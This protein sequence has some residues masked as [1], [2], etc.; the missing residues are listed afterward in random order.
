[1]V[2]PPRAVKLGNQFDVLVSIGGE[3]F[4]TPTALENNAL[5][6]EPM[7]ARPGS[8][9]GINCVP[10]RGFIVNETDANR[11]SSEKRRHQIRDVERWH[12][13]GVR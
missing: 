3:C 2:F 10:Q 6:R 7:R 1:V 11:I 13:V 8:W 5:G 12:P 9:N 4:F